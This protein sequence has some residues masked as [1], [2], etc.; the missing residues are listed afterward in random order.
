MGKRKKPPKAVT[1]TFRTQCVKRALAGCLPE[2]WRPEH[3]HALLDLL[4]DYSRIVSEVSVRGSM[5]LNEVLYRCLRSGT[6][7]PIINNSFIRQCMLLAG[8]H[9]DG[10]PQKV[11]E[12]LFSKY[13][14][15]QRQE[16]DY[17]CITFAAKKYETAFMN[18]VS[19]RTFLARQKAFIK[20]WV[21]S[22]GLPSSDTYPI[23]CEI[24]GWTCSRPRTDCST[25]TEM[26]ERHR[27]ILLT[28]PEKGLQLEGLPLQAV[29]A[30]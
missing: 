18:S 11:V 16:G 4:T 29:L 17:Q 24:N 7:L 20:T 26:I 28:D 1:S 9:M 5:V 15:V 10:V 3:R 25:V 22:Q 8:K 6:P 19:Y 13:P 14:S 30:Y 23:W 21:K 2:V 27:R 12:D